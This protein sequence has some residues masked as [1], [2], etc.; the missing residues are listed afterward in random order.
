MFS[1]IEAANKFILL[2]P[3][4]KNVMG[5]STIIT[6]LKLILTGKR[7]ILFTLPSRLPI[8]PQCAWS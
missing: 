8:H 7:K 6:G 5:L 1:L 2:K 3:L 4:I